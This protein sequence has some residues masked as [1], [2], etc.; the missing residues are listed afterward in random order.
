M[1]YLV[2][3]C[4]CLVSCLQNIHLTQVVQITPNKYVTMKQQPFRISNEWHFKQ[5]AICH[6]HGSVSSWITMKTHNILIKTISGAVCYII[7]VKMISSLQ[8]LITSVNQYP[9]RKPYA[10][11]IN[12][13]LFPIE[14]TSGRVGEKPQQITETCALGHR[15]SNTEAQA[16]G[17]GVT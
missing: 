16:P 17:V 10:L 14:T 13:Q 4:S 8:C 6:V 12:E 7:K 1:K 5:Q 11:M 9:R 3:P 2:C 15:N